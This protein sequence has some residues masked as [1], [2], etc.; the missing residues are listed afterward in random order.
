VVVYYE[1]QDPTISALE[2]FS[3]Q[4]RR[5][6]NFVYIFLSMIAALVVFVLYSKPTD[7]DHSK[8]QAT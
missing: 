8:Q 7:R 3:R 6:R 5:D 2:D 4:S 1:Y